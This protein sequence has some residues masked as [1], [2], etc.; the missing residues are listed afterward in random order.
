MLRRDAQLHVLTCRPAGPPPGAQMLWLQWT[1][2]VI[3]MPGLN[4]AVVAEWRGLFRL[5]V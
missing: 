4:L 5:M 3:D 1:T 2:Q